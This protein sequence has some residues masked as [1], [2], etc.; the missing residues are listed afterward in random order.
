MPLCPFQLTNKNQR[1]ETLKFFELP[2]EA[3]RKAQSLEERSDWI[4]SKESGTA[5]IC[6]IQTRNMREFWQI[7]SHLQDATLPR[8]VLPTDDCLSQ[9]SKGIASQ[10]F[11]KHVCTLALCVNF[12]HCNRFVQNML[13]K[14]VKLNSQMLC[15]RTQF[16]SDP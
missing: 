15:S 10:C 2:D 12:L 9:T 13:M 11:G 1:I 7:P 8:K 6:N 16:V 3:P 14:M 5:R 4:D